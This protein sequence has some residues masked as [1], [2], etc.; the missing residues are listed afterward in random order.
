MKA[1][2]EIRKE[3]KSTK[4]IKTIVLIPIKKV[5]PLLMF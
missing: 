5:Q 4:K 1:T 2:H 3:K